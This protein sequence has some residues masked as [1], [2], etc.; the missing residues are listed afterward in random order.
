ME[1]Q[2]KDTIESMIEPRLK[3]NLLLYLLVSALSFSFFVLTPRAG[4]SVSLFVLIQAGFLYVLVPRK[5]PLVVLIPVFILALNAFLSANPM[6]RIVNLA[7][8]GPLYALMALWI[9]SG[10]SLKD[11]SATLFLRLGET[12]HRAFSCILIPFRWGGEAKKESIPL[13]RRVFIGLA[14]SVPVLL[15]LIVMLSMADMIFS[16]GVE[17]FFHGLFAFIRPSTIVR[18]AFGGLVGLY[19]FGLLYGVLVAKGEETV[20]REGRERRGDCMIFNIVLISVLLVYTLFAMIQFRYLFAPPDR[21]PYG[22]TFEAY[23]R[24]GFFEL[25]F[26]TGVNIAF[27]LLTVW[28][29]KAQKGSG[30]KLTKI[31]CLY[32][33]AITV[34]LLMSSFYRMWLHGADDGLTRMRLMVF[35]FLIFEGLG[36]LVTFFYILKPKFNIVAVYCCIALCYYLLLNLVPIDRIVARDQINR[37]FETGRGG[38]DY[39]LTLSPDAAPEIARLFLSENAHTQGRARAYF[40]NLEGNENWRQWNLSLDRAQRLGR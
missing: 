10:I 16:R 5:R 8:A 3:R 21:L 27:I 40:D 36:L 37:Y 19:L 17:R 38:I 29:T 4:I 20:E 13:M 1:N 7:L 9:S 28:L 12:I 35:G 33:C 26:L 6:W 18:F 25:L 31:L 23:A 11:T 24:R 15:F 32:L 39:T 34:V 30:V 14:I 22:F 2:M